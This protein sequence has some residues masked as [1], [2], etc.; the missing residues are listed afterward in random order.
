MFPFYCIDCIING[1]DNRCMKHTYKA[2][3]IIKTIGLNYRKNS[4]NI[5][6]LELLTK[7]SRQQL[8]EIITSNYGLSPKKIITYLRLEDSFELFAN[9]NLNIYEISKRIGFT[10]LRNFRKVFISEFKITPTEFR[11][12]IFQKNNFSLEVYKLLY[13]MWLR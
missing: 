3:K 7:T 12:E 2:R 1:R 9:N 13:N 4:F 8:H 6:V 11:E 10:S 5:H